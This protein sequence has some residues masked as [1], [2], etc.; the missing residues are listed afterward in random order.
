MDDTDES[1]I[2]AY[3]KLAAA[4]IKSGQN[5]DSFKKSEWCEY[6]TE[7]VYDYSHDKL[8]KNNAQEVIT[9][10]ATGRSPKEE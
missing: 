9:K 3:M 2:P 8:N 5:D 6:L 4:I 10:A 1:T 7:T